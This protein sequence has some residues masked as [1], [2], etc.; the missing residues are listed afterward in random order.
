MTTPN[1]NPEEVQKQPPVPPFV[2]FCCAAIPQV[3]DDSLSYYEALCAM[4]KYLNDT[5]NV[6][7]NNA[8]ITEEQLEAYKALESYV[9]NYFENLDVQ[10]EINNKLDQMAQDGSLGELIGRYIDPLIEEQNENIALFE[11]NITNTVDNYQTSVNGTIAEINT[12]VNAVTSGTPLVASSVGGMTNTDRIYVNTS[13]GNWYY[14][15]GDSWEIGGTYQSSGIADGTV[16]LK[17]LA[18]DTV[19]NIITRIDDKDKLLAEDSYQIKVSDLI[20][21]NKS[22]S[23]V[24]GEESDTDASSN[25]ST[26]YIY[27]PYGYTAELSENLSGITT[28]LYFYESDFTYIYRESIYN[29]SSGN[30]RFAN[31]LNGRLLRIR[32]SDNSQTAMSPTDVADIVVTIKR[33]LPNK[34]N[35]SI[36]TNLVNPSEYIAGYLTNTGEYRYVDSEIYRLTKPIPIKA[37]TSYFISYARHIWLYDTNLEEISGSWVGT[38]QENY[39][40]TPVNDGYITFTY[41][42]ANYPFMCVGSSGTAT[43]YVETL[44]SYVQV[45]NIDNIE[46]PVNKANILYGKKYVALGDSFTHGDF[47]NAPEDDYHIEDGIYA[48]QYKVYPYLIG[49][50]NNMNII[51]LAVNGMSLAHYPADN[52]NYITDTV[53]SNIPADADYITIKIGINDSHKNVP[54]GTIDNNDRS[55]FYGAWNT[56]L[57]TIINAHKQAKIGIIVSNGTDTIDY[58][59]ATIAIAKKYGLSYINES[60]DDKVPLLIRTFR[61]DVDNSIKT[62]RDNYWFVSTTAGSTNHH[63]NAKCHEYEST[64][65]ENFLRSL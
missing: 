38:A 61:T 35:N 65:V 7:N 16:T 33:F 25:L 29:G 21:E 48:G 14:Y 42:V 27:L 26:Q 22:L 32:W 37:G 46:I 41:Q 39:T 59:N 24:T 10:E 55:T 2:Q 56:I 11:N 45:Q 57:P 62:L 64:I 23:S 5:V 4:W 43:P 6:I 20:V 15:D 49:N 12:K 13:D 8:T 63:P 47:T 54:I 51:N 53:L 17:M 34:T 36:G 1:T 28:L 31:R 3:F 58:V 50:R 30:P 19:H 9:E 18:N 60:S 40:F 44:P 52:N